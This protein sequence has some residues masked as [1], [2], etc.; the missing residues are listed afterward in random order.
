MPML[1]HGLIPGPSDE[2]GIALW[3]E[4]KGLEQPAIRKHLI[5]DTEGLPHLW[6]ELIIE[7]DSSGTAN[8]PNEK[9]KL[10]AHLIHI[11]KIQG[12]IKP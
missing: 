2:C 4:K 1:C 10:N 7:Y 3:L 6:G 8:Y 12:E 5:C 9:M 11:R